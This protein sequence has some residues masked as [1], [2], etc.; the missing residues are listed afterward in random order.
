MFDAKLSW[1][2]TPICRNKL[3]N[4]LCRNFQKITGLHRPLEYGFVCWTCRS[5]Y[6]CVTI[7]MCVSCFFL[8]NW[9]L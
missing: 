4:K 8:C 3:K 7:Q 6:G 1:T 5:P 2:K 9:C